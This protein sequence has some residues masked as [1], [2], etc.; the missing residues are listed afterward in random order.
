MEAD[1]VVRDLLG[2]LQRSKQFLGF[3]YA[4]W[5]A[6]SPSI[7]ANIALAGMAQEE[8]GHATVIGGLL[9]EQS[10]DKDGVVTWDGWSQKAGGR[11]EAWPQMVVACLARETAAAGALEA[12]KDAKDVR[13]AQRARKMIQEGQ[14]H[15]IFGVETVR[16]LAGDAPEARKGLAADYRKALAESESQLGAEERVSQLARLGLLGR[17]AAEARRKS[18]E[19]IRRRLDE[20]LLPDGSQGCGLRALRVVRTSPWCRCSAD[21]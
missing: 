11:I 5:C 12:L 3:Q 20:R 18:L 14:F 9:G 10:A 17:G 13:I 1:K 7:E 6:Q 16:S 21:S 2:A 15:L 8:I 4:S 19:S